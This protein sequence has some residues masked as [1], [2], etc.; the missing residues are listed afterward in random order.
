MKN[1][2]RYIAFLLFTSFTANASIV[3]L[4]PINESSRILQAKEI[5]GYR[6]YKKS[7]ASKAKDKKYINLRIYHL[8]TAQL[9]KKHKKKRTDLPK[10]SKKSA[11]EKMMN[12]LSERDKSISKRFYEV[13]KKHR[14]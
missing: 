6:N 9:P 7:P 4:P 13:G 12:N 2:L 11:A 8:L 3:S 14:L 5:L 1:I 10:K